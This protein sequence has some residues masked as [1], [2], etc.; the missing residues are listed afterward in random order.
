M[1]PYGDKDPLWGDGEARV[2]QDWMSGRGFDLV[3]NHGVT[4]RGGD[5]TGSKAC[6]SFGE[7]LVRRSGC[8]VTL[9]SPWMIYWVLIVASHWE[10]RP[11]GKIVIV[12]ICVTV[13]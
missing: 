9:T 2:K 1:S 10:L 3:F 5:R 12:K 8:G 7:T 6:W 13:T 11:G 4:F